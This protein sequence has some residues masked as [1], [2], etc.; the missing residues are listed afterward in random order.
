LVLVIAQPW[1]LSIGAVYAALFA[2][3]AQY[4]RRKSERALVNDLV[5]II[6]CATLVPVMWGVGSAAGAPTGRPDLPVPTETWLLALLCAL[7]LAGS[8]MHVKSL[9]RERADRRYARA[10]EAYAMTCIPVGVALAL[11]WGLPEGWWLLVPFV[12]LALR[13]WRP[14]RG[15][16]RPGQI[17]AIELVCFVA[18]AST[19]AL[20][21][22]A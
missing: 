10:S 14:I 7:V 17:G 19:A 5:F 12:V 3:N 8:T 16:Q 11:A 2:I 13:A 9:I 18:T 20:A 15:G 22:A 6:E 4:A 21:V 1:L